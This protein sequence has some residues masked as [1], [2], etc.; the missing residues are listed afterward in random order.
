MA[1]KMKTP[2][3]MFLGLWG[4]WVALLGMLA[5]VAWWVPPMAVQAQAPSTYPTAALAGLVT[6][7]AG[8]L[9]TFTR[10]TTGTVSLTAADDN[11]TAALSVLPGGAAALTMGG[12]STTAIT[13]TTDGGSLIVDGPNVSSGTGGTFT[14]KRSD[15]GTVTVTAAD[16]DATA[17]LSVLPGGAAALTLGGASTT[18]VTVTTD[19]GSLI[20]DGPNVSTGTGGTFT[21][22]RSDA[23]IVTV[24]AADDD[25]T[26]ALTVLPGGASALTLGGA[27]TTAV[28][29]TTDGTGDAE[30]VLPV[31]SI[32]PTELTGFHQNLVIC[33]DDAGAATTNYL[34]PSLPSWK[35]DGSD[36]S[37]AS[38]ACDALD[39]T[40]EAT[41]D[42]V[43]STLALK[44]HGMRCISDATQGAGESVVFTLRSAAADTTPVISCTI[45]EAATECR[46]NVATTTNIAAGATL[47]VKVVPTGDNAAGNVWCS[48]LM[49]MP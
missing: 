27:S 16:D 11:A 32:G 40:V 46:S 1:Q 18:A 2:Q 24:T 26:S 35:G 8:G 5:L 29:V 25:A 49:S 43:V 19:G 36:Y 31:N 12:S 23:G 10:P 6:T 44:A 15:A 34:G 41:A 13:L 42:L 17:A 21:V 30:V 39:N 48:V 3:G 45:A 14:V 20:V 33:G 7:D 38:T 47:A 28:T 4:A 9:F 37:L 22:K